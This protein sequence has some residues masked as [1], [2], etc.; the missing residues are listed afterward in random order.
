MKQTE[1]LKPLS[2]E[3]TFATRN[4]RLFVPR[5]KIADQMKRSDT[6]TAARAH[7]DE[8]NDPGPAAA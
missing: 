8:D 2:G 6:S 7:K 5:S 1:Y 4:V 3:E